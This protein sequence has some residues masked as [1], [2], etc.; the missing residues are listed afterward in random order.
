MS[1]VKDRPAE[2]T[3]GL[4]AAVVAV[5]VATTN[6]SSELATALV[7]VV[8]AV[9]GVVTALVSATR[10]TAAGV[11]LVALTPSVRDLAQSTLQAAGEANV[12]LADKTT[13][14]KN[15]AD[16]MSSWTSVLAAESGASAASKEDAAE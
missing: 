16:S 7:V 3:T 10:S 13:T 6:I 14:L 5:V 11:T 2:T 9:P 12:S 4:G 15:V 1:L 8:G